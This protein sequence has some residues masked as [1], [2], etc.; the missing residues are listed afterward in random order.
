MFQEL[1]EK[2]MNKVRTQLMLCGGTG[3]HASGTGEFLQALEKEL[4]R[5]GM[6]EEIKINPFISTSAFRT[7]QQLAVELPRQSQVRNRDCQMKRLQ[8]HDFRLT[9]ISPD[10]YRGPMQQA[11]F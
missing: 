11:G 4:Q 2:R 8:A 10:G 5:Q 3:C 1:Q 9:E 6:A 7:A